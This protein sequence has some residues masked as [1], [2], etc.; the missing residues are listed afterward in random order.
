MCRR[1][2]ISVQEVR[3]TR[4]LWANVPLLSVELMLALVCKNCRHVQLIH[5]T[6]VRLH[7]RPVPPN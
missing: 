5:P 3:F 2:E 6:P 4:D 7:E 1:T